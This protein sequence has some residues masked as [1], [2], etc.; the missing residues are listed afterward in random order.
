MNRRADKIVREQV[1]DWI[2]LTNKLSRATRKK[3]K[4]APSKAARRERPED[5]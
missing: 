5:G 1:K 2:P 4:R 3:H